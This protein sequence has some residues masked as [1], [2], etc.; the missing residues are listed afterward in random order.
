VKARD[1]ES[2]IFLVNLDPSTQWWKVLV[3]NGGKYIFLF[4]KRLKFDP[5]PGVAA[6]SNPRPQALVC[7]WSGALM[8][9][10][11]LNH[12]GQWWSLGGVLSVP[13]DLDTAVDC[14]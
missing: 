7:N 3:Q 14:H 1:A 11:R 13:T 2:F 5:P 10:D 9:D 8:L 6:S 12:L 4:D